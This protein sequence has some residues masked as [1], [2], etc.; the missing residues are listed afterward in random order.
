[1]RFDVKCKDCAFFKLRSIPS[2][3]ECANNDGSI[4]DPAQR[5]CD[6]FTGRKRGSAK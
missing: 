3:V 6:N 5:A 1:M 2:A 4:W